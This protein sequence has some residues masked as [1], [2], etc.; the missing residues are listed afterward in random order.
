MMCKQQTPSPSFFDGIVQTYDK[1][2]DVLLPIFYYDASC[3]TGIYT[4]DA[5]KVKMH[6]PFP[7]M[8]PVEI[9]PGRSLV[10]LTA[11]EYKATDIAPYNEFSVAALMTYNERNILGYSLVKH[12]LQNSFKTFILSLPVTTE[13]ARRGGVEL[14]GYPKFLADIKFL[15]TTEERICVVS[16]DSHRLLTF[17]GKKTKTGKGPKTHARVYT[18]MQGKAMSANLYMK[19]NAF[20]QTAGKDKAGLDIGSGHPICDILKNLNLG[21]H[22]IVYQYVPEYEAILFN[23]KNIIDR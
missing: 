22:P 13:R 9:F 15:E 4:A 16:K 20:S 7:E 6:L 19:Q 12:L 2:Y 1:E 17:H 3:F 21:K 10:A 23:P 18:S 14:G 8:K 5:E 11:F